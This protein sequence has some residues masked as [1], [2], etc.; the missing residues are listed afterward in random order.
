VGAGGAPFGL[1]TDFGGSIRLPA[2]FNGVFGH[3]ASVGLIPATGHFP[4]S[5]G[6]ASRF[7]GLGPLA[8]RAEDLMPSLRILAGPDG[9]DPLVH[10]TV[11]GDPEEV[12][13][14]GLEV[15]I[16][17]STSLLPVRRDLLEAR[18]RAAAALAQAGARVRRIPLKTMRRAVELYLA[19]VSTG[20]GTTIREL[21]AEAGAPGATLRTALLGRSE[22]TLAL[23]LGLA[24]ENLPER[25]GSRR[26][27][28]ML[29]AGRSLA[30]ELA[31]VIGDGVLLQ[32]PFPRVAPRHGA[33]VGRPWVIANTAVFNL[34]GLPVT[35]VPLGL[36]RRGLPLGVQVVAGAGRD[37]VAIAVALELECALGGWV[38]P[39]A[40]L[41]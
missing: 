18:E 7:L 1:G 22:H 28:R 40:V 6:N 32:P 11:L 5:K 25:L 33:T 21:L 23:R 12:A 24:F 3:K 36:N 16:S 10:E 14:D 29:A 4:L 17:E 2:F 19:G 9:V 26:L 8:R 38:P 15:S 31:A 41:A 30:D 39:P 13:L 34:V 20:A 37:H 27:D 35:Q